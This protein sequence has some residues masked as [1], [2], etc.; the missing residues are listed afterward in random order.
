MVCFGD[1]LRA[2]IVKEWVENYMDYDGLKDLIYRESHT[3]HASDDVSLV[4]RAFH[5]ADRD[6]L[7]EATFEEYFTEQ[8]RKVNTF[9][10]QMSAE[11]CKR[12][13]VKEVFAQRSNGKKSYRDSLKR[14]FVL[15]FRNMRDLENFKMIN[16]AACSK[17]LKKHDKMVGTPLKAIMMPWVQEQDFYTVDL[18]EIIKRTEHAYANIF[19]GGDIIVARHEMITKTS[20]VGT[21]R[22]FHLGLRSGFVIVLMVWFL[23]DCVFDPSKNWSLWDDNALYVYRS[24]GLC[25]LLVWFWGLNLYVWHRFKVNYLLVLDFDSRSTMNHLAVWEQASKATIVYFLNF[26]IY[27]KVV[28]DEFTDIIPSRWYPLMLFLYCLV[29]AFFPW[30]RRRWIWASVA[31]VATAPFHHVTFLDSY[32]G[33]VLTSLVQALSDLSYSSCFFISSQWWYN[34]ATYDPAT[35]VLNSLQSVYCH[36]D[37]G[38]QRYG[39]VLLRA[40]PSW[41]RFMQNARRY[42][43]TRVRF[44]HVANAFKY[45]FALSVLMFGVFHSSWKSA[46]NVDVFQVLWIFSFS[47]TTL[48]QWVW[49]VTQDWGLGDTNAEHW[50]LRER[51][52]YRNPKV[53]YVAIGAD[54]FLR[55]LWTMSLIPTSENSNPTGLPLSDVLT[56]VLPCLELFRRSM[57]SFFRL[58]KEHAKNPAA[59]KLVGL[60]PDA[61]DDDFMN[62]EQVEEEENKKSQREV[63][64]ELCFIVLGVVLVIIGAYYS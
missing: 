30:R 31:R 26:L 2:F 46:D 60:S 58:E 32:V 22:A 55:A 43:D 34:D 39:D 49:D 23:W 35:R 7:L 45:A 14:A 62:D 63:S 33:D 17:I 57:W 54:L 10:V 11:L 8:V 21:W 27:Y 24:T 51:L 50:G 38:Y 59:Y 4:S 19:C 3:R 41:W 13:E 44:P 48:Y 6:H 9:F 16:Y 37:H 53:Y 18:N 36:N 29:K 40:L 12:L 64:V 47:V 25:I 52:M 28:R 56:V 5:I 61:V 42:Y 20:R 15:L 1:K